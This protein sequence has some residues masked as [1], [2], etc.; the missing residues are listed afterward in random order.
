M[1]RWVVSFVVAAV[2]TGEASSAGCASSLTDLPGRWQLH[3]I[4]RGPCVLGFSGAPDIQHG[5]I[6][7]MGFCPQIFIGL[8]RWRLDAG[9]VVISNSH[10]RKL[11]ELAGGRDRLNGQTA[12]GEAVLLER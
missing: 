10:G 7:V 3:R 11:A 9:R 1:M 6:A 5:K 8:P 4:G 2:L 12:D